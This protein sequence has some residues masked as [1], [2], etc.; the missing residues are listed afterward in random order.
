[1]PS[2]P[3]T[4]AEPTGVNYLGLIEKRHDQQLQQRIDY[5]NLPRP[6]AA[7]NDDDDENDNNMEMT[8]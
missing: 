3:S 2:R 4:P 8:A 5:R 1:M 7:T 6:P